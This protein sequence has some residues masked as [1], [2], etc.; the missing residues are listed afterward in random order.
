[1]KVLLPKES[2]TYLEKRFLREVF[3]DERRKLL[4][5]F[6]NNLMDSDVGI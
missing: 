3:E 5:S 1:M 6:T 4:Y 2:Y